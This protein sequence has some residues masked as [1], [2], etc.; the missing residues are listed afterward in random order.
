MEREATTCIRV[1]ADENQICYCK[2]EVA[3]LEEPFQRVA[4]LLNMA[5]SDVRL[6]ILFLLR[7]EHQM[8]PCDLSDVLEISVPAISQHLRKMKDKGLVQSRK[9]GQTVFYS[10]NEAYLSLLQP[11]FNMIEEPAKA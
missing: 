9:A 7:R 1:V 3:A 5:G 6:K 4:G 10:I 8:C 11:L 2:R